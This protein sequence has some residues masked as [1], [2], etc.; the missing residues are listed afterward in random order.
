MPL[1]PAARMTAK[2]RYG[3]VALSRARNSM[4]VLL[5][6]EGLYI[7]T[8]TSAERLLWPQQIQAGASAP[9]ASRLYELTHWLV[10]A[11]I[12]GACTSRPAMNDRATFESWYSAP[13]SKNALRSPSNSDR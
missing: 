2:A 3:F 4:R 6:F 1:R 8:R 9:P 13:A 11:V 10:T 12:S 5:P 7:G